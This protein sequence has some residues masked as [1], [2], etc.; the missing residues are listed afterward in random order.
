VPLDADAP[1]PGTPPA[2]AYVE[3]L[4]VPLRWWAI[5][6]MFWASVLLAMLVALPPVLA[7]LMAGLFFAV[8][9]GVFVG[10]GTARLTLR[11]GVFEAGRARIPVHLLSSP[12]PLDAA[13]TRRAAGVDADA[14]AYLLIRPY[15]PQSVRVR[16]VDPADPTPYGGRGPGG[17][18]PRP[19]AVL[20]G[21]HAAPR[22]A[23]GRAGRGDRCFPG[24]A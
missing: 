2:G 19:D 12:E 15:T 4:R 5:A 23:G 7:C 21:V 3:Q 13:A 1:A 16:V 18:P 22:S 10:Y 6:T 14:R 8:N 20:A 9:A 24:G 17:A 11:D